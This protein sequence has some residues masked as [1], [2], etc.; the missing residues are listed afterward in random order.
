MRDLVTRGKTCDC[1]FR[2][3]RRSSLVSY[4]RT[5]TVAEPLTPDVVAVIVT[6]PTALPVTLPLDDTVAI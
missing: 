2:R 5:V 4:L 3:V 1:T 6:V